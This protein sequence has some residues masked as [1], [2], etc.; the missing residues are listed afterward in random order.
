MEM[1]AS[2]ENDERLQ[3]ILGNSFKAL[4]G[5]NEHLDWPENERLNEI[6][7]EFSM[8]FAAQCEIGRIFDE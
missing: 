4:N 2:C 1:C 5:G 8:A 6:P 3:E 7:E